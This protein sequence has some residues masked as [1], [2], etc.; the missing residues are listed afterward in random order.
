MKKWFKKRCWKKIFKTLL[1][2]VPEADAIGLIHNS[3][4]ILM[5]SRQD[6]FDPES[7]AQT[8]NYP[9]LLNNKTEFFLCVWG[10]QLSEDKYKSLLRPFILIIQEWL[11]TEQAKR[12]V[13]SEALDRYR[14]LSFLHNIAFELNKSLNMAEIARTLLDECSK[15]VPEASNGAVFFGKTDEKFEL[16][17][18][19]GEKGENIAE[20]IS[21]T[22]MFKGIIASKRPE[23]VN[24]LDSDPR[25]TKDVLIPGQYSLLIAPFL[26][27]NRVMGGVFLFG[28]TPFS[29]LHLKSISTIIAFATTA[30][31]NAF[32]FTELQRLLEAIMIS[33]VTAIDSRD[34]CTAGH[35]RR[36]A[37]YAWQLA[38][39]V[40]SDHKYFA[41]FRFSDKEMQEI[42]YAALLHDVG[43]IGVR[44]N[45][46][47]KSTKVSQERMNI[48]FLRL[49][50]LEK[51][52]K[53]PDGLSSVKNVWER[54]D[55]INR[56]NFLTEEEQAFIKELA[57]TKIYWEG[58]SFPILMQEDHEALLI[59]RGNLTSEEWQQ[60]K[61]HPIVS[62]K[63]MEQ[64]PFPEYMSQLLTIVR[65]HHEKLDG[66]GYPDGISGKMILLQSRIVAIC[67]IYDALIAVDRPYKNAVP[68]TKI[69]SILKEESGKG[70]LDPNLVDIF[71][72]KV[73]P[74]IHHPET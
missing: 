57:N 8:Y 73:M 64:I 10:M 9:L 58:E 1:T 69:I 36:V 19:F 4:I 47:S 35:S 25:W 40:N 67:D 12:A 63:I 23:I 71:I 48:I 18:S 5:A 11:E 49:L 21:K 53:F 60:M 72:E 29:S 45:I 50:L 24:H 30:L 55:K 28:R 15:I 7:A 2:I 62:Y 26:S 13:A 38:E 59:P 65:Q 34:P 44:E 43:K 32:H 39:A 31:T 54:L 56:S 20:K 66:T 33:L 61:L 51:S 74:D 41:D 27:K 37:K 17:A 3:K 42:Y 14:E 22:H 52:G 68:T 46:L 16:L 70:K 6:D